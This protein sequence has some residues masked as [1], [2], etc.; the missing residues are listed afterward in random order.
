[1]SFLNKIQKQPLWLKKLILWFLII[2]LGF[3]FFFIWFKFIAGN[4]FLD[5]KSFKIENS[6]NYGSPNYDSL[7]YGSEGVF[8]LQDFKMLMEN[9]NSSQSAS[10][11]ETFQ[12]ELKNLEGKVEGQDNLNNL[13]ENDSENS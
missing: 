3:L 5:L 10:D 4:Y 7:N 11:L 9:L 13:L 8:K 1:M 12:E 6:L 2:C